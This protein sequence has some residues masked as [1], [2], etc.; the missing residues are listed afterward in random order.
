MNN[1]NEK[2]DVRTVA[3]GLSFLEGPRWRHGYL[4]VSD[5][6]SHRVLKF[7]GN[8]LMN[9]LC[10]VPGQPSGLGFAPNGALQIVS[11]IDRKVLQLQGEKLVQVADLS[12][13]A[14]FHCNDMIVDG[15]GGAYIGNFGWNSAQ[16][17][18]IK[19]TV[20]LRAEPDGTV[21]IAAENLVFPNG[22]VLTP[23]GKT[24]LVAETFAARISAF[25]VEVDGTLRNR[26]SW[27]SFSDVPFETIPEAVASGKPLPDGM[28]LDA[29]GALWIG[30]A[31]GRGPV[32]VG[33]GGRILDR[34]VTEGLTAYA[35]ALGGEDRR[36]L[37]ICAAPPLLSKEFTET[38]R[39]C[40]L[41]CRVAVPG[42]GN[43]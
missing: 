33:E 16:E 32:R 20:L 24:L 42:I 26:R 41:S 21:S 35:V 8:G 15:A 5:F 13:L 1:M 38:D 23:D 36:T 18:R 43:P 2:R 37:Y 30:D 19:S 29:E 4:Y 3:K 22:M 27:A 12:G 14:P 10:L 25:D 6:F 17:A 9:E 11:M 28:A 39:A 31:G 7:D 34:V 40:L